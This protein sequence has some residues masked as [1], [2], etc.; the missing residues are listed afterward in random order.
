MSRVADKEY[1]HAA[2]VFVD[3]LLDP[4]KAWLTRWVLVKKS[5]YRFLPIPSWEQLEDGSLAASLFQTWNGDILIEE[6]LHNALTNNDRDTLIRWFIEEAKE[7]ELTKDELSRLLACT[8]IKN[9]KRSLRGLAEP[10]KFQPGPSPPTR[11]QYDAALELASTLQP[12]IFS[13]LQQASIGTKNTTADIVRFIS[14]DFPKQCEFL[15]ANLSVLEAC[16]RDNRLKQRAKA[17]RARSRV[18]ADAIAGSVNLNRKPSTAAEYLSAERHR[19]R[20]ASTEIR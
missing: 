19:R 12:A 10:F 17:I 15:I 5:R 8:D 16:L 2:E 14:K 13:F 9:V 20:K 3:A 7:R 18:L 1:Q 11:G 4:R 6:W